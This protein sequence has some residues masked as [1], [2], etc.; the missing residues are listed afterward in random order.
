MKTKDVKVKMH[1]TETT[2]NYSLY[3]HITCAHPI[4]GDSG[5]YAMDVMVKEMSNLYHIHDAGRR[6]SRDIRNTF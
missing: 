6:C 4:N 3:N 1:V 5:C 2:I